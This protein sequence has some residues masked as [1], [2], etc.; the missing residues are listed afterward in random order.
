MVAEKIFAVHKMQDNICN[1]QRAINAG[2]F[3]ELY[4]KY[5]SL[6]SDENFHKMLNETA[7]NKIVEVRFKK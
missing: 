3:L 2:P 6:K 7:M 5:T 1:I 4:A